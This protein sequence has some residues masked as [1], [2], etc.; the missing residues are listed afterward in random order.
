MVINFADDL[1]VYEAEIAK[2]SAEL[3][4]ENPGYLENHSK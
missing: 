4:L 2:D 3:Q 1:G